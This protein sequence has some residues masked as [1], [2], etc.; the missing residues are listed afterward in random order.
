VTKGE[1]MTSKRLVYRRKES[2]DRTNL[3]EFVVK[4]EE[5]D[6]LGQKLVHLIGSDAEGESLSP[7]PFY[8][9]EAMFQ[10]NYE[11]TVTTPTARVYL[12]PVNGC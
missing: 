11:G 7:L 1:R 10:E 4:H 8:L 9:N 2:S 3:P 6:G 12:E 5:Q